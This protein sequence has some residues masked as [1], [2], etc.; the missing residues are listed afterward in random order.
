MIVTLP[1]IKEYLRIDTGA[2]DAAI[3]TLIT[4]AEEYLKNAGAVLSSTNELSKLAVKIL[5]V[6]WYENH[7]PIGK[8]DKLAYGLESIITQL[9]YCYEG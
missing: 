8:T 4:A 9:Q 3:T 6:H 2:D 1:E 7:E 5:V